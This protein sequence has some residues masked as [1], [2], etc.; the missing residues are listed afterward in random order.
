M[1][2]AELERMKLL[3][4]RHE[5]Q[6]YRY[7]CLRKKWT[8]EKIELCSIKLNGHIPAVSGGGSAATSSIEGSWIIAVMEEEKELMQLRKEVVH[9][10]DLVNG[11]LNLVTQ[12]LGAEATLVLAQY[13]ITEGYENADKCAEALGLSNT[14]MLYRIINKAEAC[15]LENVKKLKNF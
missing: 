13:A 1:I 9:H 2:S 6:D 15:I 8:D 12:N 7:Y 5:L 4:I 14:R 3:R 11:W 10:I